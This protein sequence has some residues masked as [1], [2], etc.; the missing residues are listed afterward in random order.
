MFS[1]LFVSQNLIKLQ[2][3]NTGNISYS[4]NVHVFLC[5]SQ[6][7]LQFVWYNVTSSEREVLGDGANT[8][9]GSMEHL[10]VLHILSSPARKTLKIQFE[11][12]IQVT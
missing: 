11:K 5:T 6:L 4:P 12:T 10:L 2:T 1:P 3:D 8:P 9:A 7:T